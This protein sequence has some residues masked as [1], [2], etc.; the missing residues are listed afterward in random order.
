LEKF[1]TNEQRSRNFDEGER[2]HA[3]ARHQNGR[4][5]ADNTD[6]DQHQAKKVHSSTDR[7]DRSESGQY[8]HKDSFDEHH[9]RID[10]NSHAIDSTGGGPFK[11]GHY[12]P[13]FAPY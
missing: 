7:L 6:Q 4:Q 9:N 3:A 13:R 2:S 5:H 12:V 11:D 10:K 8:G 1:Y